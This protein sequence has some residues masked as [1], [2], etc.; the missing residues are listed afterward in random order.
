[1]LN[2]RAIFDLETRRREQGRELRRDVDSLR[3]SQTQPQAIGAMRRKVVTITGDGVAT[4]FLVRH[5]L[6]SRDVIATVYPNAAPHEEPGH[7]VRHTD[8]L[9]VTIVFTAAPANGATLR[10]VVMG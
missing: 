5:D 3:S 10:V 2:Y 4:S 8:D 7:V 1:M 9:H 6:G